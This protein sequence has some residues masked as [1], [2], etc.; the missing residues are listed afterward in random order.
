MGGAIIGEVTNK[1]RRSNLPEGGLEVPRIL[2]FKHED[3]KMVV[4]AKTLMKKKGYSNNKYQTHK[5]KRQRN[6]K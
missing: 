3:Q 6:T 2:T 4:K 1:Q 5:K